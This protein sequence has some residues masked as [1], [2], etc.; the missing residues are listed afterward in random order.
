MKPFGIL[1]WGTSVLM[2]SFSSYSANPGVV[3]TNLYSFA[4]KGTNAHSPCSALLQ[5]A[6]GNFYGTT[7]GGM[8]GGWISPEM[9]N[10]GIVYRITPSGALT[11]LVSFN[12]TNGAN[13]IMGFGTAG[14]VQGSDGNLY[15]TTSDGGAHGYGTVFRITTDGSLTTL[16][17]FEGYFGTNGWG[18][19]AGLVEARDGWFYG[20][21]SSGGVR[22]RTDNVGM[23]TVYR[24]SRNGAWKTLFYFTGTNGEFPASPLLLGRDGSLYGTTPNGGSAYAKGPPEHGDGTVFKITTN[25]RF[26]TLV[27]F[28]GTDG[29]NPYSGLVQASDGRLYGTTKTGGTGGRGTI[30]RLTTNGL[31]TSL[32]SFNGTNGTWPIATLVQ[33][34]DGYLYGTTCSGGLGYNGT[35]SYGN[36]TVFR[37]STNGVFTTLFYFESTNGV[38][39]CGA[40][41][42]GKDGNFYGTAAYGG[43][44]NEGTIFRFTMMPELVKKR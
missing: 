15:G 31:F 4:S 16:L 19:V 37:I 20:T 32:F 39:P 34:R 14:L 18:P 10:K 5:A 33:G 13:R 12:G 29:A 22:A 11:T 41:V 6:D 24:V 38:N 30:Y 17:S 8:G 3:F 26:T 7:R 40:L 43:A 42:Q 28:T 21:A 23:G 25:G 9:A 35:P 27:S 1:F 36:G 2:A 44:Y